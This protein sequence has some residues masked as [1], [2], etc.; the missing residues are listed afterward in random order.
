VYG[1]LLNPKSFPEPQIHSL[2][3]ASLPVSTP[4]TI[5]H[6]TL[7]IFQSDSLDL[8]TLP[9]DFFI[10]SAYE[11]VNKLVPASSLLWAL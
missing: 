5:H 3:H 8:D 2:P 6:S 11:A 10:L 9:I 7:T 4:N 1:G